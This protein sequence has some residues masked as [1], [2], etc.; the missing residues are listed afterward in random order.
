MSTTEIKELQIGVTS[1]KV[2]E[3]RSADLATAWANDVPVL[4]TPILLWL[5]ET[6]CMDAVDGHLDP[7][8]F[9]VGYEHDIRHLAPTPEGWCITLEVCLTK[10]E[11]IIL[12]FEVTASDKAGMILKGTHKRAVLSKQEFLNRFDA[13]CESTTLS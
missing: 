4:A 11:G 6:T 12:T 2:H 13:R 7:G 10:Q 9:T 8:Q 1:Q 5:A 3:V